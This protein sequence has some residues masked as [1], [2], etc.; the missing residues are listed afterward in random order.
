MITAGV[1]IGSITTKTVIL[2]NGELLTS[3]IIRTG[4]YSKQSA[5]KSLNMALSSVGIARDDIDYLVSTGYGRA[6]L[7]CADKHVTEITCHG[8][9]ASFLFPGTRT[10]I[11]IGG[12]D[13]KAISLNDKGEVLDFVMNDKC[14]AGTGRFLEVM[15]NA[16]DIDLD[17]L[18]GISLLANNEI[19]ISSMCTVF[20]ESEVVSLLAEGCPTEN[21]SKGLHNAI[22]ERVLSMANRIGIREP[23]TLSG[24]VIKNI[25]VIVAI[26]NKLGLNIEVNVPKEPQ[27]TGALGAALIAYRHSL[28]KT[29]IGERISVKNE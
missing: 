8:T 14:A 16:L 1:D 4:A 24:G 10:V 9:G 15:A 6:I 29:H 7:E 12:Q 20:A 5:I 19:E 2:K 27:I 18:G 25:G 21:I 28:E 23:V 3:N 22:A 17:K 13:S 11:D 26:R